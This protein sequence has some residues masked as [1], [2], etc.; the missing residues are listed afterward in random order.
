MPVV[1]SAPQVQNHLNLILPLKP[2][3]LANLVATLSDLQSRPD[4][5]LER[6]LTRLGNVHFA[7]FVLLEN[8]TKLGV[9][10]IYDGDFDAYILS[11]VEH[12]GDIFDAILVN[13]QDA[14]N[15]VPVRSH[16]NEFLRFIKSRD[17]PGLGMFSAYP[18][19]RLFDIKDA[20]GMR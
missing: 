7:E 3:G 18:N 1:R 13:V 5:P 9:F 17:L 6:A 4:K 20:L 2:D 12:I 8:N 11:F 19:R 16:R 10:T 14:E 15:V